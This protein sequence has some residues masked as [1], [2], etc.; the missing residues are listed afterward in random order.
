MTAIHRKN[1]RVVPRLWLM[2]DERV[3]NKALLRAVAHL[4]RGAGVI[5]RHYGLQRKKRRALF[6]RVLAAA[7][8]RGVR[9]LLAGTA[10]TARAWGADG[11]HGG[12]NGR[13]SRGALHTAPAHCVPEMR[14]AERAGADALFVSPV[15]ATRSHA[16]ARPLG[17]V[18]FAMLAR[19]ARLPVIALGGMTPRRARALAPM[20]IHGWA[21][22][23][24]LSG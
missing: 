11:W 4:P 9:V 13:R 21:A 15:H 12:D 19:Q 18:R 16:R 17:R 8:P 7:R 10:A 5:F 23:D 14:R 3:K 22:I 24:S 6:E 20:G 1:A 2:T